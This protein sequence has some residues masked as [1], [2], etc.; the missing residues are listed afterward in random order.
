MSSSSLPF[1]AAALVVVLAAL[2]LGL[3]VA[4]HFAQPPAPPPEFR[5]AAAYPEPRALPAVV[6]SN[7]AGQRLRPT[8]AGEYSTM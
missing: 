2:A 1:R 5:S 4:R 7:A 3:L 6:V 8:V